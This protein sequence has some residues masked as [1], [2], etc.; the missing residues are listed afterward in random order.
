MT[1]TGEETVYSHVTHDVHY[2]VMEHTHTYI[3]T[4]AHMYVCMYTVDTVA[5]ALTFVCTYVHKVH[6]T[7]YVHTVY[8]YVSGIVSIFRG[9]ASHITS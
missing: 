6:N 8:T 9:F 1:S 2:T 5:G 4:C 3:R 7:T